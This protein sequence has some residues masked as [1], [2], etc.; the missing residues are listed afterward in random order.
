MIAAA[1][2][3]YPHLLCVDFCT[4]ARSR[5]RLAMTPFVSMPELLRAIN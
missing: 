1:A 4:D 2:R 5:R 3:L